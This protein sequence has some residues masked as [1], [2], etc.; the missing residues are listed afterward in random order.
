MLKA[1]LVDLDGTLV[2]SGGANAA[3]YAAAL[4]ECG[5]HVEVPALATRIKG[6][7]WSHFLPELLA[8]HQDVEPA[9]V[10]RR[11]R[12][13][14]PAFFDH[15]R[16]NRLL[17]GMLGA[18]RGTLATALVTTASTRSAGAILDHFAL[19]ELFDVTVFAEHVTRTKPDPEAY[20][21][22]ARLL[23][24]TPEECLVLEDSEA[25]I[26]AAQAFGGGVLRWMA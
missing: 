7:S 20:H 18:M 15:I 14:Y 11:K 9:A 24:V 6:L 2:D 8:G 1:V 19:R 12:D 26:T 3:A 16:P 5:V 21:L 25:G 23:G 10:A 4:S 17:V 22:A 13:I